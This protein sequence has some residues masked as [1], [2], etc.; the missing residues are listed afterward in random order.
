MELNLCFTDENFFRLGGELNLHNMVEWSATNP[1]Y[2]V[3][4]GN[5]YAGVMTFC[6]VTS[7][8]LIGPF[9][10]ETNINA[11]AY[12]NLLTMEFLPALHK[13]MT[14]RNTLFQ[15][16]GA[17]AHTAETTLNFLN[18]KFGTHWIGKGVEHAWPAGSPGLTVCDYWLWNRLLQ[19]VNTCETRTREQNEKGDM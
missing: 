12:Q 14:S 9:F 10:P 5:H 2:T 1:N 16:D 3:D 8:G 4:K 19:H 11:E 6:G 7:K 18:R 15:R 13:R 17:P